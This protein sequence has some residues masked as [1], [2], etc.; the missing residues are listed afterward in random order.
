MNFYWQNKTLLIIED[1]YTNYL[2]LK[3]VLINTGIKILRAISSEQTI[4]YLS[5]KKK[6]D[7][8]IMNINIYGDKVHKNISEIKKFSLYT[9]II[10]ITEQDSIDAEHE[11]IEAGC[12][13]FIYRQIDR[14][15]L[16]NTI[17]ELLDK[18][19]ILNS[20]AYRD[21]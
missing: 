14:F 5:S 13:T 10:A 16:L 8:I 2:F 7:L 3:E 18:S 11:C 6:I 17:D 4:E 21:G 9:P 20:L 15:Q 12:D 19:N 1:D